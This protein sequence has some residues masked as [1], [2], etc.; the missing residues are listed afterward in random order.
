MMES[1]YKLARA[2]VCCSLCGGEF[3]AEEVY[4][5]V[6]K[7]DAGEM[8]VRLDYCLP[9]WEGC[10]DDYFS[11]WRTKRRCEAAEPKLDE[12][13]VFPFYEKLSGRDDRNSREL[14]YVLSLYL[15]REKVL[16]LVEVRE[17]AGD[18]EELVFEGPAKGVR[19]CVGNP[20]LS[21]ERIGELTAAIY[22]LF[23]SGRR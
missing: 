18:A 20:G 23:L 5:S 17:G 1:N 16:K 15:A 7:E 10:E 14:R 2:G 4:I 8:F 19:T 6:L 21:E 22:A 13:A 9:C 12:D 3:P 11:F